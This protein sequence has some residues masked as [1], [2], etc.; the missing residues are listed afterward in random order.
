MTVARVISRSPT[1]SRSATRESR[2]SLYSSSLSLGRTTALDVRPCLVAFCAERDLPSGR[3]GSGRVEGVFA[4][5]ED[6]CGR[7]HV[8]VSWAP[9]FPALRIY[10][11]R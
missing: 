4:V 5:G 7:S 1:G 6:L 2:N 9:V 11:R 10:S 3:H 8:F